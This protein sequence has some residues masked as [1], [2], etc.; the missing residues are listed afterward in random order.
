MSKNIYVCDLN[1]CKLYLEQPILLPCCGSTICKV[2]ENNIEKKG[3]KYKCPICGEEQKIF[4]NKFPINKKIS[5]SMKNQN[6]LSEIQKYV[7]KLFPI[8]EE[9]VSQ[10]EPIKAEEII[11]EFFAKLRNQIDLHREQLIQEIHKKSEEMLAFLK[12]KENEYKKNAENLMN[13]DLEQ[14]KVSKLAEWKK[15][16]RNPETNEYEVKNISNEINDKIFK[17]KNEISKYKNDSLM[18]KQIEFIPSKL[19]YCF[20]E[21]KIKELFTNITPRRRSTWGL[22]INPNPNEFHYVQHN[23]YNDEWDAMN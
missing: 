1:E 21:L 5:D 12:Q 18:N 15:K 3:Y 2:H 7:I 4:G 17:I 9:I 14:I 6:H 10:H 19:N 20:G 13:I 22:G 8:L 11:Y 23:L 16:I